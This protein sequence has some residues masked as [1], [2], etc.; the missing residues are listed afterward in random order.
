MSFFLGLANP[1]PPFYLASESGWDFVDSLSGPNVP[2]RSQPAAPRREAEQHSSQRQGG[3]ERNELHH[4]GAPYET[5]GLSF[6][7]PG[8]HGE[9]GGRRKE[10]SLYNRSRQFDED[11]W[12]REG[13]FIVWCVTRPGE[14]CRYELNVH[15]ND[16]RQDL[17]NRCQGFVA[18]SVDLVSSCVFGARVRV[19]DLVSLLCFWGL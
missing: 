16:P 2:P 1:P 10:H 9:V 5:V 15:T 8:E 3:G 12:L 19:R 4:G 7:V 11:M 6:C 18:R 13:C 17:E 14:N